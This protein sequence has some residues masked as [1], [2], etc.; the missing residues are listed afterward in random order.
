[1][2]RLKETNQI[3]PKKVKKAILIIF[4][5]RKGEGVGRWGGGGSH[6][7]GEQNISDISTLSRYHIQ[8]FE[9]NMHILMR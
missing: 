9:H 4:F 5:S 3:K 8:C 6:H 2:V 1:M 7:L